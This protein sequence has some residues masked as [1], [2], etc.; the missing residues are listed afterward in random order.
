MA[1]ETLVP[2]INQLHASWNSMS[3]DKRLAKGYYPNEIFW[4]KNKD[5]A[6]VIIGS[7]RSSRGDFALSESA[8]RKA[9]ASGHE[10]YVW[11]AEVNGAVVGRESVQDALAKL[12]GQTPM[13]GRYGPYWWIDQNFNP[14]S[15]R[16]ETVPDWM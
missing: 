8:L 12:D 14:P 6:R 15:V 13:H 2:N 5:D 1:T 9:K 16:D 4:P 7:R 3:S 10:A 11:L